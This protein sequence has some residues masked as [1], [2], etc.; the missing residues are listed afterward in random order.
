M[1]KI[2]AHPGESFQKIIAGIQ[3]PAV[4][5]LHIFSG[6]RIGFRIVFPGKEYTFADPP[7]VISVRG[8]F[9]DVQ[10]RFPG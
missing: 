8:Q 2:E 9:P 7:D 1:W 4:V 5:I 10:P 6:S 3:S